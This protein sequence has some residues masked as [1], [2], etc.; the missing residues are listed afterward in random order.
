MTRKAWLFTGL[1][2]LASWTL[3]ISYGL[4][5]GEWNTPSALVIALVYMFTPMIMAIVVQKGICHE[6]LRKP[7][8][9]RFRPNRWF[10]L[11]WLL[12]P[13]LALGAL[14]VGLLLPGTSFSPHM[15]G[16]FERY[17]RMLS[18]EQ[19]ELMRQ[20]AASMPVHPIW[21][22]LAQGLVAGATI[23]A[24][25]GFGEE[26]GWRGLLQ[27]ELGGVGFWPSSLLIGFIWGIWHAPLILQGHNFPDHPIL[28]VGMMTLW[29]M[30]ASPL[31]SYIRLRAR[32]VIAAAVM[33]GTLNA[34]YAMAIMTI[35]G[36]SDLS[37]GVMGL[38]G[39][40]TYGAALVILLA[41]MRLKPGDEGKTAEPRFARSS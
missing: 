27:R 39:L 10:V 41:Y 24:I 8:A 40:V 37:V 23:N 9:I 15:E 33:H 18:A 34:T 31:F 20:Q 19:I 2:F 21:F 14:A 1:T 4:L 11:G 25:A 3:A 35:D 30:M 28:G 6:P 36:G 16:M 38:A 29:C 12:P 5:G 7:L 26:L 32:S 17:A 13:V 22:A